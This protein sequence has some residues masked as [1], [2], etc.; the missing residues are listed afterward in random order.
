MSSSLSPPVS[1]A[2]ETGGT[3]DRGRAREA[4]LRVVVVVDVT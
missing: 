3:A 2:D 4:V 1:S